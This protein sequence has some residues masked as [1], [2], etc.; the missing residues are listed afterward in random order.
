M[1][2]PTLGEARFASSKSHTTSD[3]VRIPDQI[4]VGAEKLSK[5]SKPNLAQF[6]EIDSLVYCLDGFAGWDPKHRSRWVALIALF[7][8]LA[9][10]GAAPITTF[11]LS[12]Q[13]RRS[14]QQLAVELI[15]DGL[16]YSD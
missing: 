15:K 9:L 6:A 7:G 8:V 14:L 3:E 4:E 1:N 16:Q 11:E 13:F 5:T 2:T 10:I 12:K